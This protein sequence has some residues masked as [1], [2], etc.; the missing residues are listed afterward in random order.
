MKCHDLHDAGKALVKNRIRRALRPHHRI[1]AEGRWTE[2]D[3]KSGAC[4]GPFLVLGVCTLIGLTTSAGIRIGVRHFTIAA[5]EIG[6]GRTDAEFWDSVVSLCF[7]V[8]RAA[9]LVVLSRRKRCQRSGPVPRI[10][11]SEG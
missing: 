1:A 2:R 7:D 9:T 8:A 10:S 5:E 6:S 4:Y 3:R 11:G